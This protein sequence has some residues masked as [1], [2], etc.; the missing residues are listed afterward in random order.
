M[1]GEEIFFEQVRSAGCLSYILGCVKEKVCVVIDP[2]LDKAEDYVGLADFLGSKL[3]YA[4]DTHTHADHNSACKILR[5]RYGVK[6]IMHRATDAPYID[7]RVE[8][9]DEIKVGEQSLKVIHTPGHTEDAMCLL[10]NDRVFTGDTLLIGGCGRTDLPGGNAE[11]QFESLA[12]LKAL[13]DQIRVYPGHDYREA[14]STLGDE[15]QKN[16]RMLIPTKEEFIH[17]MT[18]RKPPLPRKIQEALE[19]N[20]TPIQ[21]TQRGR[22]EGI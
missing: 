3:L 22:G 18:S 1:G 6:I 19:W 12:K 13:G 11:E 9:G 16:A 15:K 2:E 10:S 14:V 21:G 20:R 17:F 4:I 8:D 5:E 7:L